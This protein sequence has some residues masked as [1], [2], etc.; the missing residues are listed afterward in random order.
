MKLEEQVLQLWD[1]LYAYMSNTSVNWTSSRHRRSRLPH[2]LTQL[3][4]IVEVYPSDFYRLVSDNLDLFRT[5]LDS[6]WSNTALLLTLCSTV[7][8]FLF[9]GGSALWNTF[10]SLIVFLTLLFYL[11]SY[12]DRSIYRPTRWL[13]NLFVVGSRG[14]GEAV[15]DAVTS[16][17]LASLKIA[18]FYGLY[19]YLLHSLIGCNLIF[20]PALAASICAVA[21]KSYWAVLPGCLDLWLVQQRPFS[22]VT[23]LVGQIIPVYVV[24]AAI[25]SEMKSGGHQVSEDMRV[26]LKMSETLEQRPTI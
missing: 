25:Y 6:F 8:S 20:L 13:N 24:D 5:I 12:S 1:R 17:F 14:L 10:L 23:L 18:C 2:I 21:L 9:T 7:L 11:L 22:A 26:S 15:N 3:Q 4:T 16:V 19:T